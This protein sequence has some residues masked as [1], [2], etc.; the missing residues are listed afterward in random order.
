M[1][2]FLNIILLSLFI[3]SPGLRAEGVYLTVILESP[4]TLVDAIVSQGYYSTDLDGLT[5]IGPLNRKDWTYL[6]YMRRL[7]HLDLGQ[8]VSDSVPGETFMDHSLETLVLPSTLCYVGRYA[9]QDCA[10]LTSVTLPD[11]LRSIDRDAFSGCVSLAS[12]RWPAGVSTVP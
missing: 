5:V 4:G 7:K 8:A 2:R 6:H 11:G 10:S 12:F 9:M 3:F 1:K